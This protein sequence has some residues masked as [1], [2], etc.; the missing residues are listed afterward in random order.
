M[1]YKLL[2]DTSNEYLSVG[3]SKDKEI[4]Y[5][6]SFK[7][8][9]QQ[10]EFL[11]PEIIKALNKVNLELKDIK[12]IVVAKGPG[13]YTGV[14]IAL[15][16]AKTIGTVAKVDV[17]AISSLEIQGPYN[18]KYI[19]VMNARSKRSYIGIYD[20]GKVILEDQILSNEDVLNL[21]SFYKEKKFKVYG[22]TSYL[23]LNSDGLEIID[24]LLSYS[25]NVEKEENILN[26][27]PVYL[28]DAI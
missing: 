19:S 4:I 13:S 21:I 27:K 9:Q 22:D 2:L 28:K 20:N 6:V 24:G 14:R 5:S 15:T 23:N 26:L 10:S 17:K 16:F 7:A 25:F 3:I 12:E 18:E 11:I 8:W 1:I